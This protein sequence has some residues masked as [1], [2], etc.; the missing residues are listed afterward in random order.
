VLPVKE[1]DLINTNL[2]FGLGPA[3]SNKAVTKNTRKTENHKKNLKYLGLE[4]KLMNLSLINNFLFKEFIKRIKPEESK[5]T[6]K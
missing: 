5:K 6:I 4:K 1:I 3:K 2:D